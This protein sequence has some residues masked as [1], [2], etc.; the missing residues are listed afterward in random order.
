MS[1]LEKPSGTLLRMIGVNFDTDVGRAA[2]E[3]SYEVTI[4]GLHM[5]NVGQR[6]IC[7]PNQHLH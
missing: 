4:S 6:G 7:V 3:R 5:K 1:R 2:L